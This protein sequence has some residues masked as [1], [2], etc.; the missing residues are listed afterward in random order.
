MSI[1]KKEI[2]INIVKILLPIVIFIIVLRE[3]KNMIVSADINQ[4]YEYLQTI[5]F[6]S[7]FY[8]AIGGFVA[9]LPMFF[10]DFFLVRH[11]KKP[12]PIVKVSKYSFISN[13][14]SNLIGFGGLIGIA[15][16]NFFYKRYETDRKK[17]FKGIAIVT[18][19]YL[20][21]ISL[22]SWIAILYSKRLNLMEDHIWIFAAIIV[23]GLIFPVL[24]VS[25]Q[26]AKQHNFVFNKNQIVG[27]IIVSLLEWIFLF[28][29]LY[30]IA[31]IIALPVS[32]G[33]FFLLFL[34]AACTGIISMI[35]GGM[36]SFELVFLWGIESLGIESEQML[37]VL[38]LYRV[39]YYLLPFLLAAF[40]FLL[41]IVKNIK[42]NAAAYLKGLSSE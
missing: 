3:I 37:I 23:V 14:F 38:F 24:L 7:L 6:H 20:S 15:L 42:K 22:L 16:R 25:Y 31:K 10:Y 27:L 30:F 17:L 18:I 8:I 1:R 32:I 36:G 2:L 33:D 41:E 35:P 29:Y 19:F 28:A 26:K 13:S 40:L 34:V 39:G 11:L 9:I 4:L 5:P 12:V 21:G